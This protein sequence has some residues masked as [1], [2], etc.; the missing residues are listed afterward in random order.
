MDVLK[1][2]YHAQTLSDSAVLSFW[3]ERLKDYHQDQMVRS[4]EKIAAAMGFAIVPLQ[5]MAE[6]ATLEE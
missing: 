3:S 1:A 5:E 2:K 4:L 6:D